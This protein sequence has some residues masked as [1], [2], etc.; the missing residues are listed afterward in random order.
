MEEDFKPLCDC[1][2]CQGA[3]DADIWAMAV[4]VV[5]VLMFVVGVIIGIIKLAQIGAP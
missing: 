3:E 5:F 1:E 2:L 4:V